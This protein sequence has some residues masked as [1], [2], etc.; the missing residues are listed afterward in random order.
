MHFVSVREK[1]MEKISVEVAYA[2]PQLQKI[3]AVEVEQGS[4]IE[5]VIYLSG[6]LN[7]FP[8]IDL[9]RQKIGVFSQARKMSDLVQNGDRI[10]IYRELL[11][12]PKEARRKRSQSG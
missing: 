7:V 6:V 4:T 1:F 9:T 11:I 12:D 3:I 10:E 8:E 2:T 5:E